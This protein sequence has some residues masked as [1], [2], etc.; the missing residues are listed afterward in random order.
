MHAGKTYEG[1]KVSVDLQAPAA[2]AT[3]STD[4]SL[5]GPQNRSGYIGEEKNLLKI[6]N[7]WGCY[8]VSACKYYC[9]FVGE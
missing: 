9:C 4:S 3:V 2:L 7:Y 6:R 5:G 8:A 1:V